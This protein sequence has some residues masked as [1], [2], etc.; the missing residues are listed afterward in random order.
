MLRVC[1]LAR[2]INQIQLSLLALMAFQ[3]ISPKCSVLCWALLLGGVDGK[4]AFLRSHCRNWNKL[5]AVLSP[6]MEYLCQVAAYLPAAFLNLK[7][8]G[9]RAIV[10]KSCCC[11]KELGVAYSDSFKGHFVL[12]SI[13]W[14]WYGNET[15][16]FTIAW[17][18]MLYHRVFCAT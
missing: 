7:R 9:L 13:P 12:F 5:P 2:F 4:L 17:S 8:S 18:R 3:F 6:A 16:I 11:F 10:S 1:V 14:L 15:G